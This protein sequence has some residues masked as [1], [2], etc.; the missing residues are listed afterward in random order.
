MDL[1]T[2]KRLIN[3]APTKKPPMGTVDWDVIYKKAV[4]ANKVFTSKTFHKEIVKEKVNAGRAK[5]KLHEWAD[6]K[7]P[8][9][10][11][12]WDSNK[13]QWSFDPE[14]VEAYAERV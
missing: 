4:E 11:R 6:T 14:V 13:Y 12:L 1:N 2:F 10:A 5:M 9:V 3:E 8:K 7:P